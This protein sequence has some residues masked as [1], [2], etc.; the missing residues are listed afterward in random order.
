MFLFLKSRHKE[1]IIEIESMK[2][3]R[4]KIISDII[5]MKTDILKIK[6]NQVSTIP[7]IPNIETGVGGFP[8]P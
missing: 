8:K 3:K 7:D 2:F 5:K 1:M 6:S 4:T